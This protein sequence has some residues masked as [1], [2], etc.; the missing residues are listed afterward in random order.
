MRFAT[1]TIR[2]GASGGLWI[3]VESAERA[4]DN[5]G[6]V[7]FHLPKNGSSHRE[8]RN[9]NCKIPEDD[10]VHFVIAAVDRVPLSAFKVNE[11]GTG[12]AQYH[13]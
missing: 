2:C 5:T 9:R 3:T 13:P 7:S 8:A 6:L 4:L 10:L 11:C 1:D 12:S